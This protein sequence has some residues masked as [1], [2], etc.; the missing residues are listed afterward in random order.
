MIKIDENNIIDEENND[1]LILTEKDFCFYNKNN[2]CNGITQKNKQCKNKIYNPSNK[3]GKYCKI[4]HK[5]FRLE[6]PNECPVC[7]E[8]LDNV[9]I[10]L[11]CVFFAVPATRL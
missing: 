11:S 2:C 3:D 5:K 6:K 8:T 1:P 7:F 9:K 10:P 4:H